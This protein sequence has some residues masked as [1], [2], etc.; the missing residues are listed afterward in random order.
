MGKLRGAVLRIGLRIPIVL[1]RWDVG[2][3]LGRR[4]LLLVH[5]GRRTGNRYETVVEVLFCNPESGEIVVMSGWG[6]SADW[7]RNVEAAEA[8]QIMIGCQRF[9]AAH[10]VL[11]EVEA[12]GVLAGYEDR[13]RW[14][15]PIIRRVLSALAGWTYDG[16]E[17]SRRS[18]VRQL[19]LVAFRPLDP[20]R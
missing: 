10:R 16:S 14:M 12:A 1:Y 2:W 5:T 4:F 11:D 18:L 6:R 7:F 20:H 13:N 17:Q 15:I 19:P 8:T 3:L 9:M